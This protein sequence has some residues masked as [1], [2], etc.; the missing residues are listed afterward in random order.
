MVTNSQT[1]VQ[2]DFTE[3]SLL[4]SR[5]FSAP[6]SLVWRAYTESELLDQWWAPHPWRVETKSMNFSAGGYWLYAMVGPEGEKHWAR[7]DYLAIDHHKSYQLKDSFCDE[8][9]TPSTA[10][11]S[12]TGSNVFTETAG[13]TLVEFKVY[14]ASENDLK[15]MVEMG[16][17][18]GITMCMEQLE[19]LFLQEKIK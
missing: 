9:G 18:Q 12:A 4:V 13:G 19:Q 10:F 14:Y 17:E 2:K 8:N 11:P 16:M 15:T 6:L 7:M 3:K 1:K 5:E